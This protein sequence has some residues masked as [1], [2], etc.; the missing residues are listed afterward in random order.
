VAAPPSVHESGQVYSWVFSPQEAEVYLGV[1]YADFA[2][3][4][5]SSPQE[6]AAGYSFSV[7][8][9]YSPSLGTSTSLSTNSLAAF[10]IGGLSRAFADVNIVAATCRLLGIP[11][12]DGE[13]FRCVIHPEKDASASV[14]ALEDG[15]FRYH[16]WHARAGLE[17]Y[18]LPRVYAALRGRDVRLSAT[19]HGIWTALLLHAIGALEL[20][21]IPAM[22]LP[23]EA[24]ERARRYWGG[25][26]L[27]TRARWNHSNFGGVVPFS[28]TTATAVC[29]MSRR[30]A[31]AARRE[32]EG[33]HA[34]IRMG[35]TG[36]HGRATP[37]WLP[38]G[39][40]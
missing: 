37:L 17:W 30:D 5:I 27:W 22:P 4:E 23:A 2:G 25:F 15:V 1:R 35:S 38:R 8:L 28:L 40:T 13:L 33:C 34:L 24:S 7:V 39:M 3:V 16:D 10:E 9:P 12:W 18:T 36:S 21:E 26:L 31:L 14:I 29:R 6:G 20:P 32:L 19:E 11:H